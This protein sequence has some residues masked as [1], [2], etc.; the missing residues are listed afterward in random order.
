MS[1]DIEYINQ[2]QID[3]IR[4]VFDLQYL[5]DEDLENLIETYDLIELNSVDLLS[6]R[7]L[8]NHLPLNTAIVSHIDREIGAQH[9]N[10]YE[11]ALSSGT[12]FLVALLLA[13]MPYLKAVRVSQGSG[14]YAWFVADDNQLEHF[15]N[16]PQKDARLDKF[17]CNGEYAIL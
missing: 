3:N 13:V 4:E 17:E 16:N 12:C 10:L 14:Y 6:I 15:N 2:T 8:I 5:T 7:T 9:F 1:D 11:K